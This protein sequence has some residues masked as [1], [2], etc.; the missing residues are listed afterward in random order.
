MPD[1]TEI[2]DANSMQF[3]L[4][5]HADP[6]GWDELDTDTAQD[7]IAARANAMESLRRHGHLIACSPLSSPTDGIEVRVRDH[8]VQTQTIPRHTTAIA[9]FYL[10]AASDP[11]QAIRLAAGIPDAQ[12]AHIT[13]RPLL[14]LPGVPARIPSLAIRGGRS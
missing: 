6:E 14:A 12:T 11:D 5:V 7:G 9:G 4:L 2:N 3:L 8:T 1:I 13:I 10:V